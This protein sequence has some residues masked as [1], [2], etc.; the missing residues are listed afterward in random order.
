M[1]L[2]DRLVWSV[3]ECIKLKLLDN[4]L[5]HK[6]VNWTEEK[7]MLKGMWS[8]LQNATSFAHLSNLLLKY[9]P[10]FISI[11]ETIDDDIIVSKDEIN[12]NSDEWTEDRNPKEIQGINI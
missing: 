11:Y 5:L 4:T 9:N 7:C 6:F 8:I 10:N 1:N 3:C 2:C 12:N